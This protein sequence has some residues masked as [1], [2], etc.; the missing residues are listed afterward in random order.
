[1]TTFVGVSLFEVADGLGGLVQ[2]VG[3]GRDR[4]DPPGL[5]RLGQM[6]RSAVFTW[7][8]KA[9][10]WLTVGARSAVLIERVGGPVR[11]PLF[12]SPAAASTPSVPVP[13]WSRPGSGFR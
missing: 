8:K 5:E 1:M 10:R 6:A 11:R 7:A 13:T 3:L 2:R 12:G 4:C 9:I